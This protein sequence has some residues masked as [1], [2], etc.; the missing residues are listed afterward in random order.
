MEA[1][2]IGDESKDAAEDKVDEC[3]EEGNKVLVNIDE[4][5]KMKDVQE[6]DDLSCCELS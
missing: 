1:K 2:K 4:M 6:L 5:F 3:D